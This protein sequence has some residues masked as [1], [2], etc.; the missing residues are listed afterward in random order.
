VTSNVQLSH[1]PPYRKSTAPKAGRRGLGVLTGFREEGV[2]MA[3]IPAA[4]I[5]RLKR[6]VSLE[7]LFR[8]QVKRLWYRALSKRSQRGLTR[9]RFQG[10]LEL[11]PL[12]E[13]R[14]TH[15]REALAVGLG[16]LQEE[17]SAGK[18]HARICEGES[19]MAEL[20]DQPPM[21]TQGGST[22]VTMSAD[23]S[24]SDSHRRR[25][26]R[27]RRCPVELI[28]AAVLGVLVSGSATVAVSENPPPSE[29]SMAALLAHP[30]TRST[31]AI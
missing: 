22:A 11:F 8:H 7:R 30:A 31:T 12:P 15:S 18:P 23:V 25:P 9:H 4:E 19:R 26:G 27:A 5:E 16:D 1:I 3:R 10:L 28:C 2:S 13:P 21:H 29:V 24:V 20:L 17:P 6:E 14:I